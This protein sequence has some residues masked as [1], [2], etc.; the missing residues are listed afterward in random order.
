MEQVI[1]KITHCPNIALVTLPEIPSD[2]R[3]AAEILT[4]IS[5]AGVNV[6]MISQTAPQGSTISLAF[7]ISM[8]SMAL[9]LPV[10]NSLK[11]LHPGLKCEIG[12]NKINF[13]DA[14]MVNTP[15]VAARVFSALAASSVQVVM[16]TTSTVDISIL[17]RDHEIE[18]ALALCAEKFG[19]EPEEV[20]FE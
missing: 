2:S 19:T 4:A 3:I 11:P 8:D 12:M 10:I 14:N 5:D 17:V 9:L 1:T 6:D 16:I 15:G 7:S 13:Y 18:D 20:P